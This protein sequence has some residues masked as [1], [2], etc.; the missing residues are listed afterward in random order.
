MSGG[1]DSLALLLLAH[2]AK[3]PGLRVATVDHRLRSGAAG[4]AASVAARCAELGVPHDLLA[5]EWDTP[6]TAN[7]QARARDARYDLL[8][9]WAT[10]RTLGAVL[11]AHHADDQAETLVMRLARG[12]GVAGLAGARSRSVLTGDVVRLRPLLGWRRSELAALVAEAGWTAAADPTNDD[13]RFD[14]TRARRWLASAGDWPD[15]V[16]VAASAAHLAEA[17]AALAFVADALVAERV[18]RDGDML[19][20]DPAG[21]PRELARRLLEGALALSGETGHRRGDLDRLLTRLLAGETAT[22]GRIRLVGGARWRLDWPRP[23]R[24]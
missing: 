15:P 1:G 13:P 7:I 2:R 19:T 17:E 22:I 6:P 11:T 8:G 20:L 5:V 4:E 21:L 23:H 14:R 9:R 24:R 16:A 12:S 18:A 3:L 10:S